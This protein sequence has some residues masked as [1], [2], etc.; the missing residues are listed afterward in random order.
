LLRFF[1]RNGFLFDAPETALGADDGIGFGIGGLIEQQLRYGASGA[2]I[3]EMGRDLAEGNKNEGAL[4]ET[5]VRDFE[6]G[7]GENEI[8]VEEDIE[9]EGA[10]AAGGRGAAVAAEFNFNGEE[11]AEQS[12]RGKVSLEGD[13]GVE[14]AGLSCIADGRSGVE[15]G[16][17]GDNAEG[18]E[19]FGGFGERGFR[20]ARGAGQVGAKGY[21]GG[22][23]CFID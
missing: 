14:E 10:R 5:W 6:A 18:D 8:A 9:V 21:V 16:A 19:A 12:E 4:I 15:R 3:A 20:R 17:R 1:A 11:R 13:D 22:G 2:G 7:D 23:H